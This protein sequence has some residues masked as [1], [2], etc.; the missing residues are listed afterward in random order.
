ML[1]M[2]KIEGNKLIGSE[3]KYDLPVFDKKRINWLKEG[4]VK[5]KGKPYVKCIK[6]KKSV[7]L[8]PEE[9]VQQLMID[10]LINE[11]GYPEDLIKVLYPVTFGREKKQ[12]DI[13]V[14]NK[15]DFR[16][17]FIIIEVKKNKE[18]DGMEQLRSYT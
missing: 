1:F 11:Y 9:I 2:K 4:I 17:E 12:A 16:S 6:R 18:K 7:A 14:L 8:K 10:K 5:E 13:V 15:K 3:E